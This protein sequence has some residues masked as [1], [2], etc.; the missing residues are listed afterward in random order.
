MHA[1]CHGTEKLAGMDG[2][3]TYPGRL[4]SAPQTIE[5]TAFQK[6][7]DVRQ[8]PLKIELSSSQS[9]DGC[10][11]APACAKLAVILAVIGRSGTLGPAIPWFDSLREQEYASV[12]S[13]G[14]GNPNGQAALLRVACPPT[15]M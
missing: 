8:H 11:C 3:R 14:G 6:S 13:I 10:D 5:K 1:D 7:V 2:N 12:K 15:N 9:T 4:N